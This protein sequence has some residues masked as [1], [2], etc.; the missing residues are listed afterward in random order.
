[1]TLSSIDALIHH[2]LLLKV[3]RDSPKQLRCKCGTRIDDLD[4][5]TMQYTPAITGHHIRSEFTPE[6]HRAFVMAS[7]ER[8][9]CWF[10]RRRIQVFTTTCETPM[11]S[12]HSCALLDIES[13]TILPFDMMAE[14]KDRLT[15]ILMYHTIRGGGFR[16][17][18]MIDYAKKL[19][20][21]CKRHYA[22]EADVLL[23]NVYGKR[24]IRGEVIQTK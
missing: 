7:A 2:P 15:L 8:V 10:R 14:W 20:A 6:E 19:G 12:I 4:S 17:R 24:G 3:H 13:R 11:C 21:A 18:N 9:C 23:I 5:Y 22:L 1:M 16:W